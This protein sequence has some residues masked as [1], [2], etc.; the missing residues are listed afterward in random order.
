MVIKY[1]EEM[2]RNK[3]EVDVLL[4]EETEWGFKERRYSIRQNG[5]GNGDEVSHECEES[6]EFRSGEIKARQGEMFKKE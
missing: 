2:A 3:M 4:W 5:N 6:N 1:D